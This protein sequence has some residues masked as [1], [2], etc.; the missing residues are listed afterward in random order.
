V[1]VALDVVEAELAYLIAA[2]AWPEVA[3]GEV[4]LLDAERAGFFLGQ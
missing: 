2:R 1:H 4:E 3:I